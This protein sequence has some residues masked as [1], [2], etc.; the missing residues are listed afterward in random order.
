MSLIYIHDGEGLMYSQFGVWEVGREINNLWFSTHDLKI[1]FKRRDSLKILL[2]TRHPKDQ[3]RRWNAMKWVGNLLWKLPIVSETFVHHTNENWKK[4]GDYLNSNHKQG[5][6]H[7][8]TT[9]ISHWIL[10][11]VGWLSIS[12][13]FCRVT[14]EPITVG[15]ISHLSAQTFTAWGFCDCFICARL[16]DYIHWQFQ[17]HI[18][19]E[20]WFGWVLYSLRGNLWVEREW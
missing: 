15:S 1:E 7:Q 19:L 2:V 6:L 12:L 8:Y 5:M 18:I 4:R 17:H 9:D 14:R 3:S 10:W 16:F 11:V 13:R 20:Y